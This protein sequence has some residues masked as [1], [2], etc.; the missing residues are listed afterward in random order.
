MRLFLAI[1]LLLAAALCIVGYTRSGPHPDAAR[2]RAEFLVGAMLTS[3][4]SWYLFRK[5][6]NSINR[7][8]TNP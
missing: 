7:P 2:A 3:G 8:P 5:A 1:V 4:T 6:R